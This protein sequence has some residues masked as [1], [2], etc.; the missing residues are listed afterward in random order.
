MIARDAQILNDAPGDVVPFGAASK[1]D[2]AARVIDPLSFPLITDVNAKHRQNPRT[3]HGL[4]VLLEALLL[5]EVVENPATA[6]DACGS[7]DSPYSESHASAE[8]T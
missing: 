4:P 7:K 6:F 5:S 8:W 3:P 1:L 2:G